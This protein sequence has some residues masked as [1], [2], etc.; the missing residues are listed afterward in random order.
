MTCHSVRQVLSAYV[1]EPMRVEDSKTIRTHLEVCEDCQQEYEYL[2]RLN[3]PLRELPRVAPPPGL[4]TT[5]RVRAFSRPGLSLWERWQ[6]RLAN[7][8]RPV[9]LP[10][11]GGLL[12]AL[13][14]FGVLIP[15]VGV[16]R[17]AGNDVPTVLITGP[18]V[19]APSMFPVDEDLLIEAWVDQRGTI[20]RFEIVNGSPGDAA[21]E[22]ELRHQLS[23]VMLTTLFV[24]A[25][26][27]GQPIPGK[28]YLSFRRIS[29][30]T[31]RG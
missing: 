17:F 7:L 8:M 26:E 12:A 23:N 27:F 29:R 2:A 3:S 10:A 9:A 22:A 21:V 19:K 18:K 16:T 4:A 14:L 20:S 5:I 31:I 24:P 6:V 25:T 11:A 15:G 28:V 30:I 1:D 13:I